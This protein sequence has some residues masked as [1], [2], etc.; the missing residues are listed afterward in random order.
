MSVFDEWVEVTAF[1]KLCDNV[2]IVNT[3]VYIKAFDDIRVVELS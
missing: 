2:A 3:E 1:T